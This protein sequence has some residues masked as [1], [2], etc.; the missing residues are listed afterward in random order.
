MR[1]IY[2]ALF[3]GHKANIVGKVYCFEFK[4]DKMKRSYPTPF[5]REATILFFGS[6]L[7]GLL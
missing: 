6:G 3:P 7:I 2:Q 5:R 1:H 4:L